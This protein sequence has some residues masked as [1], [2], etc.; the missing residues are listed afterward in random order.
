MRDLQSHS[1]RHGKEMKPRVLI[2]GTAYAV[3][4]HRKKLECLAGQ[5][6]LTCV[7]AREC[8][9]FGWTE[10]ANNEPTG[11]YRLVALPIAGAA[12]AGTRCWYR[13]M[14]A[15]FRNGRYDLIFVE[16]EPWGILRWQ[17]WVLKILF[18][19][20]AIFGEFTWENIERRGWRGRVLGL[21][22]RMATRTS[23]L[24][25]GGNR[26]AV[27]LM[28]SYGAV[29]ADTVCIPQFGVDT[30]HFTPLSDTDKRRAR[31]ASEVPEDAFLIGFCGRLTPEKGLRD[32]RDAFLRLKPAGRNLRLV[33]MGSGELESELYQAARGDS[34][35]Q[36][37]SPRKHSEVVHFLRLLDVLVL[38]S[39]TM[40]G[41]RNWWKEQFG[42][43]LIEA[44]ACGVVTIGSDCGAIPEVLDDPSVI[45]PEGDV[46]ALAALLQ[47]LI[48]Q[49][50]RFAAVRA[51]QRERVILAYSQ[52]AVA[53]RWARVLRQYIATRQ[54]PP[55][56]A[57]A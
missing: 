25:V 46:N 51:R 6:D 9:G 16:N 52:A 35:I 50:Q 30:D 44:M 26:D 27:E 45:F 11:S 29:P 48:M 17:S 42:H 40:A 37:W 8:S 55:S 20:N 21:I 15:I 24:V 5:F 53:D 33:I 2:V 14:S 31:A 12:N 13:G 34:R 36:L 49:H 28:R 56:G 43:I 32:L 1:N 54:K 22:Y 3:R 23:D 39:R 57:T 18:Q 10:M 4:E 41:P 38:P 47:T 7:T 19:R